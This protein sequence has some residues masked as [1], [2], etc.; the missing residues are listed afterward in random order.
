MAGLTARLHMAGSTR[1]KKQAAPA[2][3]IAGRDWSG[4]EMS[5]GAKKALVRVPGIGLL[6]VAVE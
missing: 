6:Q 5:L 2:G 1:R 4:A 3:P